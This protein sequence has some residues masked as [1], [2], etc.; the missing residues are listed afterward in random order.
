MQKLGDRLLSR[1]MQIP[2][3]HSLW[4]RFPLGS[5]RTRVRYD[6]WDRPHYAFGVYSAAELARRLKFTGISVIE[7]GVAGGRGLIALEQIAQC[8]G[9]YLGMEI[10]VFGFDTGKGMP[11]PVDYRDLPHIW[12]QGFYQ[13]R[14]AELQTK[15]ANAKL[16]LGDVQKTI[17]SFMA[18]HPLGF[19]A[20][21]LDY[22]S[23]TKAAFRIFEGDHL[24]RVYCYF[25]DTIWPETACH[26]EYIGELCAIREFNAEHAYTKICQMRGLRYMRPRDA[27]WHEQMY[28]FHDFTHSLYS[29]RVTPTGDQYTQ[30]WL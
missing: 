2:G 18:P 7:F 5:V 26:N 10:A 24:P 13:I 15:L 8:V 22:Y 4:Q 16:I 14:V 21:D 27:F 19:I 12:D 3:I 9:E 25:D 29:A 23:A 1:L 11:A 28:V 6:L 17:P 20:F 30:K